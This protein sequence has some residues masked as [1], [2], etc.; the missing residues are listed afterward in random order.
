MN[1]QSTHKRRAIDPRIRKELMNAARRFQENKIYRANIRRWLIASGVVIVILALSAFWPALGGLAFPAVCGV[2]LVTLFANFIGKLKTPLN[3]AEAAREVETKFP[4][5]GNILTTALE[6]KTGREG[7]NFLQEK[8]IDDA[9][10]FSFFQ[11]WEDVGKRRRL[12]FQTAHW[13][14]LALIAGLAALTYYAK[15][16][17]FEFK[18]PHLPVLISSVDVT[19]GNTAIERGSAVVIAARFRGDVPRSATLVVKQDDG[20]TRRQAMARS[21][22]DPI[23]A[24]TLPSVM[25]SAHYT[26][27][28]PGDQTDT[29]RLEVYDLP[30]LV[31][32][33]AFLD[34]PDYTGIRDR[35]I[36]DTRRVSAV[37]GTRL[38]YRFLVNKPLAAAELLDRDGNRIPLLPTN[39]EKTRFG[40][41]ILLTEDLR[42]HLHLTDEQGRANAYPPDLRIAVRENQKP[43]LRL[44]FPKGDQAVSPIEELALEAKANDDFGLVDYGLA[45]AIGAESP[46]YVSLKP[47]NPDPLEAEFEKLYALEEEAV[48]V[49][50]L[51]TWFAWADDY[52]VDGET[53]RSTSDLFYAEVRPLEEIYRE[54]EGG[55]GQ[56]QGQPGGPE[57]E[58]LEQQRQIA[59]ATFKLKQ[60]G[61]GDSGFLE[62][63]EVLRDS[64]QQIRLQLEQVKMEL[65]EEKWITAANL[66]GD[67][68]E[69]AITSLSETVDAESDEPLETAWLAAQG[70]Y[71]AL[72]RMRPREMNVN[73]SR[74]QGGG[75]GGNNRNQRQL[76]Q[77]EFNE[78]ENRYETESQA[79]ALT[80]PEEREQLEVLSKLSELA[81]RQ[82][83]VNE[84]LR[85]LQTALAAAQDKEERDKIRR[86]LK[87]LE[88]EQRRMLTQMDE[89]R[90][91]MD[92]LPQDRQMREAGEQLQETRE[93]MRNI[94][95]S[96]QEEEVS[97]ALA[98][99]SRAQRNLEELKDEFRESTSSQFS[100]AMRA[101]RDAAR[102]LAEN[103]R[104]ISEELE[105]L[106]ADQAPALDGSDDREGAADRYRQQRE[107]LE[108]LMEDLRRIT[109]DSETGEPALH[110][111]LYDVLRRQNQSDASGNLQVAEELVR[112]GFLEQAQTMQPGL[113]QSLNELER[114]VSEAAES[115]MGDATT[116]LRFARE[117]L[118]DLLNELEQERPEGELADNESPR[119]GQAQT[120][121]ESEG[122]AGQPGQPP[123][124]TSGQE[125][126][127]ELAQSPGPQSGT[128]Q[129][130]RQPS[131]QGQ[132]GSQEPGQAPN[133]QP[134]GPQPGEGQAGGQ[135]PGG[136]QPGSSLAQ[137]GQ[138][139]G[140][141]NNPGG[142]PSPGGQTGGRQTAGGGGG[143][144]PLQNL[145][146]II[147]SF[148]NNDG[149]WGGPIT[150]DGF[151]D[152]NERMRTI[153]ELMELPQA[154]ERMQ[155]AREQAERMRAD[156]KRHGNP[157]QWEDIDTSVLQ[158]VREVESWVQ[159]ELLRKE[160]PDSLQPI[161][162]DP[163]PP[164][165]TSSVKKYY[166][167]LGGD[168]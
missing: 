12:K 146:D 129:A 53:R 162:R 153:E 30:A 50:Q 27:E 133:G 44:N 20:V 72:L 161:D 78:E 99:G 149:G 75:G 70:A 64:Q 167:A 125:Q 7:Y 57:G 114:A 3:Y 126:E 94:S 134:S 86:E 83:Q 81:R 63:A 77:L 71:Q 120:G 6:Q 14:S 10:R 35:L 155:Q 43:E 65:E 51:V 67:Y 46:E 25:H 102:E 91:R 165:Y 29:F 157:P 139:P 92:N 45:V 88:E 36:E 101:V 145:N 128:E 106:Q 87:R 105:S 112:R 135:P 48:E 74:Q 113:Q 95:E 37:E 60:R 80:T 96:L 116:A 61:Q 85:E 56:G 2:I 76:N 28:Y 136:G 160:N 68:M 15:D 66:A 98:S 119:P 42:Y 62:D 26:V 108:N 124:R 16:H 55:G 41:E 117:E 130:G 54:G 143:G 84:R 13:G 31:Q 47:D 151:V 103:Q 158:P 154:R 17:P 152:W 144:G 82:Q 40:T 121:Q 4:D 90:Q 49:D 138:Q 33:N 122:P 21:L 110:R 118:E 127:G 9:L 104:E 93:D 11:Y 148:T 137:N 107:G 159:Q 132:S 1:S 147:R 79:Q 24:H 156:F 140:R 52:G 131:Q 34:Y 58:L 73:Q 89:V 97:Q 23:F 59:I 22:S 5:L 18:A 142:Q 69:E 39:P 19:P 164:K 32:A 123:G 111:K 8:V 141:S 168:S 150:G 166:E 115:V 38:D 100:D 163:V 109:E